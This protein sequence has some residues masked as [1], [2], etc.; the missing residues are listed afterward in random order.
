[1]TL[2]NLT[3]IVRF[4]VAGQ[5]AMPKWQQ[6]AIRNALEVQES[7]PESLRFQCR[8]ASDARENF[9]EIALNDG[10]TLRLHPRAKPQFGKNN[11]GQAY[12]T[13]TMSYSGDGQ[14]YTVKWVG[15][16]VPEKMQRIAVKHDKGL[17]VGAATV[18]LDLSKAQVTPSV[19]AEYNRRHAQ[20]HPK[21]VAESRKRYEA[22]RGTTK[23]RTCSRL[24]EGDL[25]ART[26]A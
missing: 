22:K 4:Q 7:P 26:R 17:K 24:T 16:A 5:N 3:G 11:K 6:Q 14:S 23:S 9:K 1:M 8:I 2:T 13:A 21:S 19:Y 25:K 20:K 15:D 12:L 18:N 10:E